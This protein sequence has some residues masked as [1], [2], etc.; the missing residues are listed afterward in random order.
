MLSFHSSLTS[1]VPVHAVFS[2]AAGGEPLGVGSV[3]SLLS[4]GVA[5]ILKLLN[6]VLHTAGPD[7][8]H[9]RLHGVIKE[10]TRTQSA[11]RADV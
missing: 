3:S 11:E 6:D 10:H 2:Q 4:H 5:V 8:T 1:G 7:C 9:R